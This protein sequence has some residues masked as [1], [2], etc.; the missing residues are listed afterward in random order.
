M[1]VDNHV[2]ALLVSRQSHRRSGPSALT[3]WL[4]EHYLIMPRPKHHRG[5]NQA[6]SISRRVIACDPGVRVVQLVMTRS[7]K[8]LLSGA[9]A[10]SAVSTVWDSAG[11]SL[12][13]NASAVRR[14][15]HRLKRVWRRISQRRKNLV[16]DFHYCFARWLCRNF[17]VILWPGFGE[18]AAWQGAPTDVST[19]R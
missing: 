2:C 4:N 1:R 9:K 8:E 13:T 17:E 10:T 19:A 12:V 11:W 5:E 3:T 6:T 15:R 14:K 18:K 16:R 7:C